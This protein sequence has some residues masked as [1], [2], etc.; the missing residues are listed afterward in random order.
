M[1]T[2]VNPFMSYPAAAG[3]LPVTRSFSTQTYDGLV[4]WIGTEGE[5]AAYQ[6]PATAAVTY[7]VVASQVS[8]VDGTRTADKAFNHALAAPTNEAHTGNGSSR[9]WRVDFGAL[10]IDVD[11]YCIFGR[12]GDGNHAPRNWKLQGSNDASAWT[13]LDTQVANTSVG[14]GTNFDGSVSSTSSWRYVRVL[15]T[16]SNSSSDTYLV[17][18]EVEFWGT[19]TEA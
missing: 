19:L 6:N 15:Q 5:T 13:D 8:N 2:L 1:T 7:P 11:H 14:N 3:G 4:N 17:L 10:R 16:G 12:T 9:W 18:G